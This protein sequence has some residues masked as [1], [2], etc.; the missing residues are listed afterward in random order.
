GRGLM[1]YGASE[2]GAFVRS[3]PDVAYPD[4]QL[5]LSP[6]TFA[7]GLL[8]GKLKL[9]KEPGLTII[10]YAL[11]PESRGR[12]MIRHGD[13]GAMPHIQPNWLATT[14]DQM[15]AVAMMRAM[16]RFV[17]QPAIAQFIDTELW[18]GRAVTSNEDLLAQF[19]KN[20]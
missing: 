6:Y 10:G 1:G 15:T 20:F 18:P 11:R 4:I 19:R 16:R 5:S 3:R 8:Q 2:M 13:V 17:D 7:R 14:G 12:V 9:E